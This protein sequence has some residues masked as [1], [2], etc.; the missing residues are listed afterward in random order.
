MGKP[1]SARRWP[2][3]SLFSPPC[4]ASPC[5]APAVALL[6]PGRPLDV[7]P[8]HTHRTCWHAV[9]QAGNDFLPNVPSI[10][11]Y[12]QPNGLDILFT[13]YRWVGGGG[14]GGRRGGMRQEA[15]QGFRRG[16]QRDRET[17]TLKARSTERR[18]IGG[19]LAIWRVGRGAAPFSCGE[20]G[21]WLSC[22]EDAGE[23]P[24]IHWHHLQD[25]AT[26]AFCL[27]PCAQAFA[28]R[29]GRAPGVWWDRQH[30]AAAAVDDAAGAG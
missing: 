12:D 24:V 18:C 29:P 25:K 15:G 4:R 1:C 22:D 19:A 13:T 7:I 11:I 17:Q 10:A 20:G 3:C 2:A 26:N 23:H 30:I 6:P 14:A 5:C 16:R 28:A 21:S 9:P 8:H 27:G